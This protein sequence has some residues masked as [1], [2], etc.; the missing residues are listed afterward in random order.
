MFVRGFFYVLI[1]FTAGLAVLNTWQARRYGA[2]KREIRRLRRDER[3][4]V[5]ENKKLISNIARFSV[6]SRIDRVA[7]EE[8]DL[9]KNKQEDFL[10]IEHRIEQSKTE[11]RGSR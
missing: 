1:L 8:F 3:N 11:G 2:L 5:E 6:L 4:Y 10:R 7:G 9:R